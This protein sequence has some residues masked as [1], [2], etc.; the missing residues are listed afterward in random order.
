[1]IFA[2]PKSVMARP[3]N[4]IG[5]NLVGLAS[6]SLCALIPKPVYEVSLLVY[7][8]AVGISIFIM[9]VIDTE[10]PPAS[11]LALGMA[12]SGF[13]WSVGI[14]VVTTIV[15]LSLVHHFFKSMIHDLV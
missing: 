2:M 5:G 7:A 15:V 13:S 1:M 4:V 3:Q 14:V 11:G 10:H 12:I 9:V 6:G 8:V